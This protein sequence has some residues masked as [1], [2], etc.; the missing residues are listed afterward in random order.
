MTTGW[1]AAARVEHGTGGGAVRLGR[2]L[3]VGRDRIAGDWRRRETGAP[4]PHGKV[5]MV[6][7]DGPRAGCGRGRRW[8]GLQP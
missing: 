8:G 5:A 2:Q 3:S 6:L 4:P 7:G 1:S